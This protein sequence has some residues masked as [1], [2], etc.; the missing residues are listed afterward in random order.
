MLNDEGLLNDLSDTKKEAF[1]SFQE[2]IDEAQDKLDRTAA[3][4]K[5][6]KNV[7]G[8]VSAGSGYRTMQHYLK[9]GQKWPTEVD[10]AIV[11]VK[12]HWSISNRVSCSSPQ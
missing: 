2:E 1:H 12:S 7:L 5:Q 8:T 9:D 3:F 10:W 4:F 6:S 11:A